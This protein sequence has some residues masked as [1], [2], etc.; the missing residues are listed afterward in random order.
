MQKMTEIFGPCG[1][2]IFS[3][4]IASHPCC[5]D[6]TSWGTVFVERPGAGCV[7]SSLHFKV[8]PSC[9]TTGRG[10]NLSA[11]TTR[12]SGASVFLDS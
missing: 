10:Y 3:C 4:H 5:V 6:P 8:L 7:M 12:S 1:T 2:R 9:F 11:S